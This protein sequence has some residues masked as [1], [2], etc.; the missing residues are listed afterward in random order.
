[1]Q[2]IRVCLAFTAML[3]S[4]AAA[5]Y[6]PPPFPRLAVSWLSNQN[7]GQAT[8]QSQLARADIAII[9]T[10]PGWATNYTG[11]GTG[12]QPVLGNIKAIN[13]NILVFEYIK[14][15]EIDGT[16]ATNGAYSA[17][18]N[19]LS[20][21]NW[22]LY[23]VGG[24]GTPVPSSWAGATSINNTVFTP[25]DSNGDNWL[26]WFAKWAVSTLYTPNPSYDGFSIDNVFCQTRVT[27]DWNRD[28][29]TDPSGSS[30]AGQWQRQGYASF[31]KTLR[32]VMPSN[33][34]E[35][36][37]IG[38][39]TEPNA[40]LTEYQGV[41]DGGIMEA[42]I[43]ETWSVEAWGGWQ[44]MM[45]GYR[46]A[47]AA[48]GGP[49]LGIFSQAGDPTD[50]QSFRYGF[51][52]TMMDDGYYQFSSTSNYNGSFPWFDEYNYQHQFGAAI[53]SPPT[54]AWQNGVYRRDYTN[55][56]ALVNP[57]GNG[58]QTVTLEANY[59]HITGTQ[60][61]SINNGQTV[62]TLTLQD[63]DGVILLR[64]STAPPSAVPAPPSNVAVQ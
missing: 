16:I 22:Y 31:V 30:Q 64:T 33:K 49:K 3:I 14:N 26:S 5:A 29:T 62:R 21:M 53:S 2:R 6:T 58:V 28:G 61:P 50:Y 9:T 57:K 18:F 44:A 34:F 10:W 20:A 46:Q 54:T 24:S 39:W 38:D 45:T 47:M 23:P 37:N 1:M 40:V 60:A 48:L 15:N 36:G 56:I 63:R 55:G 32:S 35:I 27:G 13:P 41:L 11:S 52:S 19:K 12:I 17:L 8:I 4:G 7:Y 59:I 25:P 51:A 43:G 42:M